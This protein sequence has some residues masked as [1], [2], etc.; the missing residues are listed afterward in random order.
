L[1]AYLGVDIGSRTVKVILLDEEGRILARGLAPAGYDGPAVAARLVAQA[2]SQAG[3]A[4]SEVAASVATG[5]GRGRYPG[6]D[7]E[8]SEIT[9]HARGARHLVPDARTVIDIG[10][11]DSKVIRL[12]GAGRVLDFVM[13]DRCAAGTGRFLEVM[14]DALGVAVSELAALHTRAERAVPVSS[15]CTVFAE[16]EVISHL[17][18]GVAPADIVAGLHAAIASRV[19]A[20]AERVGLEPVLTCTGGVARNAGFVSALSSAARMP[21]VVPDDA[22]FAGALGAALLALARQA[23]R[24]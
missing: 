5:Y 4:P 15:T 13:N 21:V 17:A 2:C 23:E 9:C 20:L 11:Q 3:V 8:S 1:S 14:A 10:G 24:R 22:Q 6:A 18:R 7:A 19:L 12:D 16:S